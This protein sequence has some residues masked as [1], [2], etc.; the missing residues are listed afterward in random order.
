MDQEQ[1][2]S[3]KE[4]RARE[5]SEKQDRRQQAARN[6]RLKHV[7][8]WGVA[9]LM[10]G[11]LGG[12]LAFEGSRPQHG[13]S[14]NDPAV[15]PENAPVL[16]VEY[17]DYQCPACQ[18]AHDVINDVIDEYGDQ[19][20]VEFNDFAL[21]QHEH[22]SN[23]AIGAECAF[24]QDRFLD[25]HNT[26]FERQPEWN[27]LSQA[28]AIET[29]RGYAE[30]LGLDMPEFNRCVSSQDAADRVNEDYKE[31][32]AQGLNSTPTILVNGTKVEEMPFSVGLRHAIDAALEGQ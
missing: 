9:V 16:V 26:V 20:R 11:G 31:A 13:V 28:E 30:E 18:G 29:F 7:G 4:R 12:V 17:T 10:I 3:R 25:Y 19:I 23:A 22:A 24:R 32:M 27:T 2:E 5:R 1:P 15:G 8:A 14:G 21:S 6:A